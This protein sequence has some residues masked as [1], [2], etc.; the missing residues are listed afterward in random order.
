MTYNQTVINM[1]TDLINR[2]YYENKSVIQEK[3]NVFYAMSEISSEDYKD[4][5]IRVDE[6]Y[7]EDEEPELEEQKSIEETAE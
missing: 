4:L 2:K 1:L 7:V 5:T 3:L 6:V